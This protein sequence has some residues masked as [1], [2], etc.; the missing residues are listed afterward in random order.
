MY[1]PNRRVLVRSID[2]ISLEEVPTPQPG[3]RELL[4][5]STVIGVC[6]SDTHAALGHHPFI[7]LP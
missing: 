5:R 7:G 6:G 4:V 1:R 3:D 2:D